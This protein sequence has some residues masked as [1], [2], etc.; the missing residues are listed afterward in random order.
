MSW[1][2]SREQSQALLPE[3]MGTAEVVS[4]GAGGEGTRLDATLREQSISETSDKPSTSGSIGW[5]QGL[6]VYESVI[7]LI[8]EISIFDFFVVFISENLPSFFMCCAS[9]LFI[10]DAGTCTVFATKHQCR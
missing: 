4:I 3:D 6:T 5:F 7:Y 10:I 8:L 2:S 1:S 9:K